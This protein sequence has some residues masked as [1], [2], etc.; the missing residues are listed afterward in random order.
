[1]LNHI[2]RALD[3]AIKHKTHLDTVLG[4]RQQYLQN[5]DKEETN[6]KFLH[7]AEEVISC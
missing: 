4:H 2:D 3:L 5:F 1:M 6:K 7:Y